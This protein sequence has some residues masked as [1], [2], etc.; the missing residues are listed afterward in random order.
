V[1]IERCGRHYGQSSIVT[2]SD[3]SPTPVRPAID[4]DNIEFSGEGRTKRHLSHG[5]VLAH[6]YTLW[7]MIQAEY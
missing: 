5:Y 4:K 2:V 1:E 3:G 6:P 7:I